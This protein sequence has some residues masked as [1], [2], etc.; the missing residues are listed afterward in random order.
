M[1]GKWFRSITPR[2]VKS[3]E[4]DTSV[5][6]P[7]RMYDY[8]LGGKDNFAADRVAA[9]AVIAVRPKIRYEV[10]E[11][12]KFLIRSVRYLAAEAGIRQFLELGAGIPIPPNV[13][14]A[15]QQIVPTCRVVY[16]DNDP[17]VLA[18]ARA[19]LASPEEG[20]TAFLDADL[21]DP[22]PILSEA[23][24]TLD[25]RQPVA[26][27][28]VGVL[29]LIPDDEKPELIVARL[30]AEVPSG[31]YLVITQPAS[32]IEALAAAEGTRCYNS[33]VT[34]PQTRRS[35]PEVERFFDSLDLVEPG[36]VQSH[37][38]RPDPAGPAPEG[39]VSAWAGVAR[40][41]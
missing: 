17:V 26:V 25:F 31:S 16:V 1:V 19:Q 5:A 27:I 34:I 38:W 37:S 10:R 35:R 40:K 15:A 41:P 7:A 12:R 39:D 36:L 23:A 9:E 11:N 29:H 33:F 2:R 21:R 18:H 3:A 28:L 22:E 20:A 8:W 13:H 24:R 30:M 14:E 4:L 32:D 6:H